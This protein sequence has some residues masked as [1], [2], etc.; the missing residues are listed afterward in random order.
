MNPEQFILMMNDLPD[1]V[2][3]SANSPVVRPKHKIGYMIPAVAAC[4]IALI[5]A[6]VYPKL[7]IQTPESTEPPAATVT[8]GTTA[9]NTAETTAVTM[10]TTAVSMKTT[11]RTTADTVSQTVTVTVTV[12]PTTQGSAPVQTVSVM[13]NET[14]PD[15]ETAWRTET[16]PNTD[17]TDQTIRSTINP[18]EPNE[19]ETTQS[20]PII[21]QSISVPVL[22]SE[23]VFTA[24]N[25]EIQ[26]VSCEFREATEEDLQKWGNEATEFDRSAYK[27]IC[28]TIS[29]CCQDAVIVRGTIMNDDCRLLIAYLKETDMPEPIQV[30]YLL[31]FPVE[32]EIQTDHLHASISHAWGES[33]FHTLLDDYSKSITIQY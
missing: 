5:A 26:E 2:I 9:Q 1:S 23:P 33:F 27:L 12:T 29:G 19:D 15:T 17:L 4:F 10:Y 22:R 3:D 21:E 18:N 6:A 16:K 30:K 13:Q 7:R 8:A 28:A 24:A 11:H 32:L 14:M 25:Q 20:E 31:A